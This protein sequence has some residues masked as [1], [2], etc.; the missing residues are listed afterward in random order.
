M[1]V[2]MSPVYGA[3]EFSRIAM[4]GFHACGLDAR[5]MLQCWGRA[6]RGELGLQ[7]PTLALHFTPQEAFSPDDIIAVAARPGATCFLSHTRF[8]YCNG[9]GSRGEIGLVGDGAP[10]LVETHWNAGGGAQF[11]AVS[12]APLVACGLDLGQHAVCATVADSRVTTASAAAQTWHALEVSSE[13]GVG[14]VQTPGSERPWA[15]GITIARDMLC[16]GDG[17]RGQ[18]GGGAGVDV[19]DAPSMVHGTQG[20]DA[21]TVGGEFACGL[22]GTIASCWGRNDAGQLG[23]GT[24]TD[25]WVPTPV[26]GGHAFTKLSAGVAHACGVR[27]DGVLMCWGANQRGELGDGTTTT[28]NTPTVTVVPASPTP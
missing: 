28:R 20:W 18:L 21:I 12:I 8:L 25:R 6:I 2:T 4:G 24:L 1:R 17:Y 16:W 5:G 23:D 3:H 19:I 9:F 15:C 11:T 22:Q 7:F 14:P 27:S 10:E 13:R 26:S